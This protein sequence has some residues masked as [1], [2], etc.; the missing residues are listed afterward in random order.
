MKKTILSF[1]ILFS[2]ISFCE[3][4]PQS[5]SIKMKRPP[6]NQLG[7]SN[8][9]DL[10][11]TN[12]TNESK[13]F[14][15]FGTLNEAKSGLIAS[16]TTEIIILKAKE[17]KNFKAS[18]LSNTPDISY[19]NPDSRYKE[20]LMRK[21][22]LP[23]GNYTI[24]VTAKESG[25]NEE[26]GNDC[27]E[28]EIQI[29]S[30]AEIS[31][32][33]PENNSSIS[34][35]EPI[36]FSWFSSLPSSS[37]NTYKI[38]IIEIK[39]DESPENA[40]LRNKAF[41]EKEDLRTT[42]FTYPSTGPKFES[43]KKYAWQ[44]LV[45]KVN[46]EVY[47]FNLKS[48]SKTDENSDCNKDSLILN[49]GYNHNINSP[50]T[51]LG[52][53]QDVFWTLVNAPTNNGTVNLNGPAWVIN[54]GHSSWGNPMPG[55][56][57]ISAFQI[58]SSNESNVDLSFPAYVF[59]KKICINKTADLNFNIN[60]R[61]DNI[62]TINFV[63][64][65]GTVIQMIGQLNDASLT[66]NFTQVH[67]FV[68]S[69]TGVSPGTY[70]L[71]AELRNE[72]NASAMGL[73]IQGSVSGN[74]SSF[75]D[76]VCCSE[77]L[78]TI[79]GY[80]FKDDNGNGIKDASEI[81]LP[82]WVINTTV[83]GNLV[84]ST[85]DANGNF[86]FTGLPQG[87][88]NVSEV[89][90]SGW[91]AGP[92]GSQQTVT[93]GQNQAINGIIFGNMES[94]DPCPDFNASV[95]SN[96]GGCCWS[97]N[98]NGPASTSG[99]TGIQILS[100]APNT[101]VTGSSQLGSSYNS[102][103]IYQTN[104]LTEFKIKRLTGDIPSGQLNGF[105]NFCLNNL[106]NPQSIV[107]NWLNNNNDVVCSDTV[108]ANCDIPCVTILKDTLK[109]DGNNYDLSFQFV[110]NAS[111]PVNNIEIV[112][113][114]PSGIAISPNNFNLTTSVNS[115]QTS[116]VISFDVTGG[117]QGN[118]LCVIYKFKSPDGCCW[119][120][121]TVCVNIPSCICEEV[122]ASVTGDAVN[123]CYNLSLQNTFSNSYFNLVK[124]R[125]I[126]NGTLFS[127][128]NTNTSNNYYSTNTFP[129]NEINLIFNPSAYPN[130]YLPISA[131]PAFVLNYCL[132]N[133]T[134]N[135]QH[136]I[137]EWMRND[138]IVCADTVITNCIPPPPVTPCVQ[139]LNDSIV[140]LPDGTFQYNFYIKN[141]S[142]HQT[143]GFQFNAVSPS[144]LTFSQSNFSNV[145]IM[146]GMVSPM[147]STIISGVPS[148]NQFCFKISLYEH[149]YLNGQLY[150]DWCCYSDTICKTVNCAVTN[151]CDF[152][153]VIDSANCQQNPTGQFGYKIKTTI[154]NN[155]GS[156]ATLTG[157]TTSQGNVFGCNP[158]TLVPGSNVIN[159][160]FNLSGSLTN[161]VCFNYKIVKQGST[162]TCIIQVCKDLP[163]CNLP[164]S[165]NCDGAKWHPE[166][167]RIFYKINSITKNAPIVCK[168]TYLIDYNSNV[169]FNSNYTCP[170]PNCSPKFSYKV[171][172]IMSGIQSSA[173]TLSNIT[174]DSEVMIYAYCGDKICDS[175]VVYFKVNN[176]PQG[177]NCNKWDDELISV[178]ALGKVNSLTCGES[179]NITPSA[180]VTMDF[181]NFICSPENCIATYK[182][183][184][185]GPVSSSGTSNS[186]SNA[187]FSLPG[188]YKVSVIPFC[189]TKECSPCTIII[190]V[191]DGKCDCGDFKNEKPGFT[192]LGNIGNKEIKEFITCDQTFNSVYK[193]NI[194]NFEGEDYIC[195]PEN[196]CPTEYI[197]TVISPLNI[198]YTF[199]S[200]SI[201][202]F[203]FNEVGK[204]T[205]KR[206]VICNGKICN[207]CVSFINSKN[208]DGPK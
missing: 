100:L 173:Y 43:G 127:T 39:G 102:G 48:D 112:N 144:G 161:P 205:F 164:Q 134:N 87:S 193:G 199:N 41:F 150:Y 91:T 196:A 110:N 19:P 129:D 51:N 185:D 47:T 106:S 160:N 90:Q 156:N 123:C 148:G 99:I 178:V 63:D 17:T 187:N 146:P 25:T 121:D 75:I 26:L 37:K 113:T 34:T 116:P 188:T 97:L 77:N 126:E 83:N 152:S 176:P 170:Q 124:I 197:W 44:V 29:Q 131:N 23:D 200:K 71:Q 159:C 115:G 53:D 165:C 141:N 36:I 186:I 135:V 162:D 208:P 153:I 145:S 202:G 82:G 140:C 11:L 101:F 8:L 1:L 79:S 13:T 93:V 171:N 58:S 111:Y 66:T 40:M 30:E 16:A 172:G 180:N 108:N 147:Q 3:V 203:K 85:T 132:T 4:F 181:P 61:V 190:E 206:Q 163:N 14:Y 157:V 5:I 117:I 191:K 2:F 70:Y 151:N 20:A 27:I 28:Q 122:E 98:L 204:Y 68:A 104:S 125:P 169:T 95:Q 59:R 168:S 52:V 45:D 133:Y 183:F 22:S 9:Y 143:T 114:I 50:Y 175:C 10:T 72:D 31:V 21:G 7:I 119:C 103:W 149:L 182:W 35:Q 81:F 78:S 120:Y 56:Q 138:T 201:N 166:N 32:L 6:L 155:T 96:T 130:N 142:S 88:Y 24:C 76:P 109:C 139:I 73:C 49:T 86:I 80:K 89:M 38:K 167:N 33:T 192:I 74:N 179:L 62:V 12:T 64:A 18:D 107:V 54:K 67:N 158:V 65:N 194:L 207:E 60:V 195:K 118:S 136:I 84:S 189:G 15:L 177:C 105:F 69:V 154:I 57:Y 174:V 46:S 184:I 198:V 94:S 137:V 92:T 42:N 128:W 55:S